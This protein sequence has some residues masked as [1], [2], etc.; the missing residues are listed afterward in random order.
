VRLEYLLF[1]DWLCF[2]VVAF[3][4]FKIFS[5]KFFRCAQAGGFTA[6]GFEILERVLGFIQSLVAQLVRALH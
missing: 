2:L 5:K 3:I 1:R 4:F 6:T